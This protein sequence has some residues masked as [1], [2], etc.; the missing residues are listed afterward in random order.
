MKAT[1]LASSLLCFLFICRSVPA[2]NVTDHDFTP[3]VR[4]PTYP[5][6]DGPAVFFDEAHVNFHTAGGRYKPFTRLITE[7]GYRVTSLKSKCSQESLHGADILV[8]ANPRHWTAVFQKNSSLSAFTEQE[9][10][11]LFEWVED[12]GALLLIADHM[13]FAGAAS[14]L[15]S[16]FGFHFNN[17]FALAPGDQHGIARFSRD[18]GSLRDHTITNGLATSEE[19]SCVVTY[20][21][22]AFQGPPEAIPL[23]VFP[24]GHYSLMPKVPMKFEKDTPRIAIEGWF[25]GAVRTCGKGR[26]AVF[27]EAAAFTAQLAGPERLKVGINSPDAADNAQFI[28]NVLH[29]LSGKMDG[30]TVRQQSSSVSVKSV[31]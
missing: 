25:Q 26:I 3:A 8:I 11:A 6:R 23:L 7:D 20:T 22:Q 9:V 29:W 19:V 24:K 30:T 31:D 5:D 15:G 12:G 10:A 13:P 16:A 21:G 28:L 18:D 17:G 2:Q 1:I 14:K 27:G 4:K